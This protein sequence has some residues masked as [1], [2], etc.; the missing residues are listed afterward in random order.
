VDPEFDGDDYQPD[1]DKP[2]LTGQIKEVFSFI[3]DQKWHT[4]HRIA[5]ITGHPEPSVSAQ[6]RNLRKER[7]GGHTIDRKYAGDGLYL[8]RLANANPQR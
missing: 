4:V 1:R 7:F 8:F 5:A 3:S 2:R 6:L